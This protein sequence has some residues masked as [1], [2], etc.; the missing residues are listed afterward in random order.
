MN[1]VKG[2]GRLNHH[3][4]GT[5][6][7]GMV[8]VFDTSEAAVDALSVLGGLWKIHDKEPR[9]LSWWGESDALKIAKEQLVLFGADG[10]KIDSIKYS[11]DYGEPFDV[12][13]SV[14]PQEQA[15]LF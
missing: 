8:L 13:I 1:K 5:Y 9:A 6:Y 4:W 11:I 7:A 3:F 14:C 15:S 12:V 2:K 10:D